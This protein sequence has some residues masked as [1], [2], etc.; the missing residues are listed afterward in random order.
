MKNQLCFKAPIT[1]ESSRGER[2]VGISELEANKYPIYPQG[3]LLRNGEKK[4]FKVWFSNI[5]L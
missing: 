2:I 4:L 5:S 3:L 1:Q